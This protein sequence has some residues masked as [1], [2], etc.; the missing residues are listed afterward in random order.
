MQK[1]IREIEGL[2]ASV[3]ALSVD[4]PEQSA[5]MAGSM[6]ITFPLISD[7]DKK[8]VKAWDLHNPFEQNGIAKP[9]AFIIGK[10]RRVLFR[11]LERVTR[12]V[13]VDELAAALAGPAPDPAREPRLSWAWPSLSNWAHMVRNLLAAGDRKNWMHVLFYPVVFFGLLFRRLLKALR[14]RKGRRPADAAPH[15]AGQGQEKGPVPPGSGAGP[16]GH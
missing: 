1:R 6:G 10:D 3:A 5:H 7:L 4:A 11:A 15:E 13:S 16:P 8:I 14:G 2:G 12:R 9:A